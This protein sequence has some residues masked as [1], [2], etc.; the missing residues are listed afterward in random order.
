MAD[1]SDRV[2]VHSRKGREAPREGEV[3]SVVG[4]LLRIRWSTGEE[5]TMAPSP[6]SL[7]VVGKAE[8]SS[9]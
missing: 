6:G 8:V 2:R 3:A 4:H 5:S 1:V 7:S 9:G